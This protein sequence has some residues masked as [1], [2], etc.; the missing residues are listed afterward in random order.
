MRE[1]NHE[2]SVLPSR[3]DQPSEQTRP[4]GDRKKSLNPPKK[5]MPEN[6]ESDPR[7]VQY[8]SSLEWDPPKDF[9]REALMGRKF[10][11]YY[12]DEDPTVPGDFWPCDLTSTGFSGVYPNG[13]PWVGTWRDV[14][15]TE[16]NKTKLCLRTHPLKVI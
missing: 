3:F 10:L 7:L 9:T 8:K 6:L 15:G 13:N 1:R 11:L 16:K 5:G 4:K 14:P 2:T 12:A